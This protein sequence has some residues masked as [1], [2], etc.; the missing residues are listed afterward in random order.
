MDFRGSPL[1][2]LGWLLVLVLVGLKIS[3]PPAVNVR[4]VSIDPG[5]LRDWERLPAWVVLVWIT[6]VVLALV[7]PWVYE[8]MC[9]WFVRALRFSD[10]GSADFS[11]RGSEILGWWILW[12]LAGGRWHVGS[13]ALEVTLNLVGLWATVHILRWFVSH[14]DFN[15]GRKLAFTGGFA[16]LLG[17][18]I[19]LALSVLTV[20]GWAWVMAAMYGWLARNIRGDGVAL[21]FHGMGPQVLWRTLATILF[22]IPVITIPWA[23]LWYVRWLVSSTTIEGEVAGLVE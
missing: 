15:T 5:L 18:E 4:I 8:G 16:E 20:I 17:W 2:V 6:W 10:D 23:W 9:R 14:V 3:L 12:M 22:S 7:G 13:A 11:G 19:L 21:R 1:Q